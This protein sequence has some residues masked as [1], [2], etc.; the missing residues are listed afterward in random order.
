MILRGAQFEGEI[1]KSRNKQAAKVL[2][3]LLF[4][5]NQFAFLFFVRKRFFLCL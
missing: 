3:G 2:R 1:E 5:L 4:I